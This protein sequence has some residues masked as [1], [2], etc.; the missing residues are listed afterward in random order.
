[1]LGWEKLWTELSGTQRKPEDVKKRGKKLDK[2]Q[3]NLLPSLLSEQEE[4]LK[5]DRKK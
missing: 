5:E 1:M 3:L 2:T 4:K